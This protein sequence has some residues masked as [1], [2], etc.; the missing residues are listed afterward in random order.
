MARGTVLT[1]QMRRTAQAAHLDTSPAGLLAPLVPQPATCLLTA[2][3]T[4]L[5]VLMEQTRDAVG[6][7]SLAISDAG[8]RSA[9]MRHGC[10]TGSLTVQTAVMS[11]TAPMFCPARSLPPQSLAA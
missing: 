6:I 9:C 10:A 3:T 1:A 4:R 2:A 11:G 7:A 5:S 8:M